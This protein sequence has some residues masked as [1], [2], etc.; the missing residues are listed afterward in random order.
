M[1]WTLSDGTV[2]H[3]GG[4]IEGDSSVAERFRNAVTLIALGLEPFDLDDS[5]RMHSW[6]YACA[7]L[8]GVEVVDSPYHFEVR[9]SSKHGHQVIKGRDPRAK[10]LPSEER[11]VRWLIDGAIEGWVRE[12]R[13]KSERPG[14]GS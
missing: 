3:L 9:V 12:Q 2:V 11:F 13:T 1:K 7:D 6:V 14:S 4:L 5:A 10:L 8:A